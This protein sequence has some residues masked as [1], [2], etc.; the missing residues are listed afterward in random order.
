MAS[1]A[2][3]A[4]RQIRSLGS[5]P[6]STPEPF[7]FCVYH[8]D[9][10]P[11]GDEK[12]Q[13]PRM[14]NGQDFNPNAKWRMYHGSRIPGFPQH[15]HRGFE[16][17]TATIE[18]IID[19]TD[20]LKNGG[21]YG[22][23]DLQWMTAGKGIVHG[24]MF[25]LV[26]MDKPNPTRFFQIWINLPKKNKMVQPDYIM[27]WAEDVKKVTSKDQKTK[28]TVWAG[29]LEGQKALEPPK[30]SWAA[31]PENDVAVWH[32]EV[33]PGGTYTVPK[34]KGG[35]TVNRSFYFIEGKNL[36]MNKEKVEPKSLIDVNAGVDLQLSVP[37]SASRS[38]E[39]LMLQGKPIGE[40]VVQH[41]PFVMNTQQEI[42]QAFIDYQRTRF[43]GWPWPEDDYVFPREKGR[44]SKKGKK[45]EYPPKAQ[46]EKKEEKVTA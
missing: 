15:P 3:S 25:P 30:N 12:M 33:L 24:E 44:F 34:A 39:L 37:P 21:R 5:G 43:G 20:S 11:E 38:S 23:G 26:N 36:E 10:Y 9:A 19:H 42:M 46:A 41:G 16:T 32:I 29:E 18:G 7:L 17:I 13:A 35:N 31:Y 22:Q 28:I 8:K 27:H 40:P 14:G 6:F 4:I 45:V 1:K 2:K